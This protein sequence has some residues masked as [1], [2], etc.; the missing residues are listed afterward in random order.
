MWWWSL[1]YAVYDYVKQTY[2]DSK[3]CTTQEKLLKA[4]NGGGEGVSFQGK[5]EIKI[6]NKAKKKGKF[7]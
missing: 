7:N 4:W 2:G 3:S 1:E 5:I 6:E